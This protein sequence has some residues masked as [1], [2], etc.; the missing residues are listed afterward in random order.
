MCVGERGEGK[1]KEVSW[2]EAYDYI[3]KKLNEIKEKYGAH[4][5]AFASKTGLE[6]T[7]LNQFAYSYGSPNIFDHG[8]ICPLGYTTALMSVYDNGGVSRDFANCKFMLNFGHNVYEGMVISYARGITEALEN[9]CKLV[10]LDP[11]FSILSSKASEW[12]PIR[13]GGDAAFMMA[14]LH[15]LI[16][17][18]LYDKKFVEKYTTGFDK[19]KESIKDYTPEKMAKECDI[20]ADKIIALARECASYAPHCM[21]D[22]GHRATFTP[23]EIEF[24]RSIAIANALLGN[25]E[26]KGGL[27]FPKGAAL[28]NKVAGE[29][30]API[31]KGSIL[32]KIPEPNHPRI[33]FVDVKEGEFSKIPKNRGVY[34]KI[35]ECILSENPYA[36]KG[37][38]ITRSNPV[39]TV[40]G[41]DSVVEAIKKLDLFVCGCISFR[42]STICRYY[43]A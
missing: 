8:N 5:V 18:G 38:F 43:S 29:K 17:E 27:Y 10:S 26:V 31:I 41:A 22:F 4:T 7:F 33:D 1:W 21:V 25:M 12:I 42:Y 40:A 23:E 14:F 20:P 32:P 2:E 6:Q 19:L 39:M 11:R 13:P 37:V 36:L 16:F 34:S 15:T 28:Y 9:G 24:R 30:V 3:A 35:Y